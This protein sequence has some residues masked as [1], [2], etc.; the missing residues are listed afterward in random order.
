M[1]ERLA[2]LIVDKLEPK[3]EQVVQAQL[4]ELR[5]EIVDG[6]ANAAGVIASTLNER[7]TLDVAAAKADLKKQ[8]TSEILRGVKF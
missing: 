3:I 5:V 7:I 8:I 4:E 1:L 6:V 2:Q